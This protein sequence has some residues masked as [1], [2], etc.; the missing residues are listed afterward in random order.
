MA[1]DDPEVLKKRHHLYY[2]ANIDRIKENTKKYRESHKVEIQEKSK[3]YRI[4][5]KRK[6]FLRKKKY[7]ETHASK[8]RE[9]MQRYR[10]LN[11]E[12]ISLKKK[13]EYSVNK[14]Y[15]KAREKKYKAD[16]PWAKTLNSITSR[17]TR[18]KSYYDKGIKNLLTTSD[19][20]YLWFRD[21]AYEMRKPNIHRLDNDEDY[22]VIN[23]KYIE[24]EEHRKLHSGD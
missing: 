19:L 17:V 2:L 5:N 12:K 4:L 24:A 10:M 22:T 15:V 11:K 1:W 9:R 13:L 21:K 8:I 20:K 14:N 16:N 3:L 6:I 23:C 18:S 7:R